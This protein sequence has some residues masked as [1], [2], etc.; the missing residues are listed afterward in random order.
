MKTCLEIHFVNQSEDKALAVV[1]V[2]LNEG[3][4]NSALAPVVEKK[5]TI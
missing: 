1:A 5:L 3:E 4:T 2:M